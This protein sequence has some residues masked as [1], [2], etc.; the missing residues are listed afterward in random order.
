MI[1]DYETFKAQLKLSKTEICRELFHANADKI[2]IQKEHVAVPNLIRIIDSTLR[3]ANSDGFHA[4]SL[5]G[6]CA[7][8]GLSMGGLYAY[9]RNKADLIELIQ[10]H[11][12]IMTR[13]VMLHYTQDIAPPRQRL[14]SAIRAHLYLSELMRAW[15]YFSYMEA[16]SL[17]KPQKQAAIAA[18]QEIE[19]ILHGVLLSGIESAAFAPVN[20]RLLASLLKAMLQDWY[21]KRGKYRKQAITVEQYADQIEDLLLQYLNPDRSP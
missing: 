1:E 13:R 3:L 14:H 16:K 5:R 12:F 20:A 8:S 6:L 7:D 17:A 15:F 11:G 10:S 21:L 2:R 19:D 4:M 9:I 18:E